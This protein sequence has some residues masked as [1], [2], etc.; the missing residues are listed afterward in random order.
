L[1]M[2]ERAPLVLLNFAS[3]GN[4]MQPIWWNFQYDHLLSNSTFN[5]IKL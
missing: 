1:C 5:F 3:F 2:E 4:S